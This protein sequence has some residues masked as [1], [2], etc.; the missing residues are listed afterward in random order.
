[1]KYKKWK[2]KKCKN[3]ENK[4]EESK[5]NIRLKTIIKDGF[6]KDLKFTDHNHDEKV[7][8]KMNYLMKAKTPLISFLLT[9]KR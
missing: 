6:Q 5:L 9:Y 3:L 8:M 4:K 2:N 1:M 7:M